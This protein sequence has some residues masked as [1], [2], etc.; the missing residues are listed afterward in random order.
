[1]GI[2][3]LAGNSTIGSVYL[4]R[5]M[6]EKINGARGMAN[7]LKVVTTRHD[8]ASQAIVLQALQSR[9]KERDMDAYLETGSTVIA[10]SRSIIDILINLLLFMAVLIA[11]VGG[12]GLMGTMGMNVLERT[13]EIGVMRSIGAINNSIFQLVVVEGMLIGVI[14]WVLGWLAALPIAYLLNANLGTMLMKVPLQF[15]FSTQGLMTWLAVVLVIAALASLAPARSAVRLTIRDV[16][17][18][19]YHGENA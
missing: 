10:N 8:A 12:L 5:S 4:N 9:L 17:A 18:Y 2:F 11:V 13:R 6:I 7:S 16:L 14:S 15:T 1:M 3:R 19:E